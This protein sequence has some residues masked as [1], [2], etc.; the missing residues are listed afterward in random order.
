M[1][2]NHPAKLFDR[3]SK[4]RVQRIRLRGNWSIGFWIFVILVLLELFVL[5]PYTLFYADHPRH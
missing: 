3:G 2:S 5:V 1:S 4:K